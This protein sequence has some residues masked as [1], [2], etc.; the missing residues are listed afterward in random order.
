MHN[1]LFFSFQNLHKAFGIRMRHN[2]N[3]FRL[4]LFIKK[5][6]LVEYERL[7]SNELCYNLSCIILGQYMFL[8][9]RRTTML[10]LY[11]YIYMPGRIFDRSD[12]VCGQH[13]LSS[14][15]AI[16]CET[17]TKQWKELWWTPIH[18]ILAVL[19]TNLCPR[20]FRMSERY[21]SITGNKILC[22]IIVNSINLTVGLFFC[23][24]VKR[25]ILEDLCDLPEIALL[26]VLFQNDRH[27]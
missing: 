27:R 18:N 17:T 5:Y 13:L 7:S 26:L 3:E 15:F 9:F 16:L 24:P 20:W 25:N 22:N 10:W 23:F 6:Y 8:Y 12:G 4:Y 14:H 21:T 11:I 2:I 1:I 19:D